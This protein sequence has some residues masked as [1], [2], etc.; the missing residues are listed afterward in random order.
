M[1]SVYSFLYIISNA[2][3]CKSMLSSIYY[4]YLIVSASVMVVNFVIRY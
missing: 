3:F 1:C 2:S 4:M